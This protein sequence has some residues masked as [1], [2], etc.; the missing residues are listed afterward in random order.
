MI[1]S[2]IFYYKE[3]SLFSKAKLILVASTDFDF[4]CKACTC[5]KTSHK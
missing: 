3:K 4:I 5:D 2:V 1:K